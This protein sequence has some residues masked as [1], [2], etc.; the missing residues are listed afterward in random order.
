MSESQNVSDILARVW[1]DIEESENSI[2]VRVSQGHVINITEALK[3]IYEDTFTNIESCR[4]GLT[5]LAAILIAA[6]S[7]TAAKLIEEMLVE[8]WRGLLN[9][10]EFF[11]FNSD[12]QLESGSREDNPGTEQDTS[13]ET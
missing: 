2:S 3:D 10:R 11:K 13:Q 4:N 8:E 5:A 1:K 7:G 12:F 6:Q 9:D